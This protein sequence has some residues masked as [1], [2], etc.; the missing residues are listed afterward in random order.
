[1]LVPV[2]AIGLAW[3]G[4]RAALAG[5]GG[6][7]GAGLKPDFYRRLAAHSLTNYGQQLAGMLHSFSF[8][9]LFV[10]GLTGPAEFRF[11]YNLPG[12]VLQLVF[13]PLSGIQVPLFARLRED[14]SPERTQAAYEL[15][16]RGMLLLFCPAAAGLVVLAP[17]LTHIYD[18]KYSA[19]W[20]VVAVTAVS[21]FAGSALAVARNIAM[22]HEVYRPVIASRLIGAVSL[23]LL[24]WLP[25]LYGPLGA[26]L[27]IGGA[28]L[29]AE[30]VAWLWSL[31]AL[32]LAYPW[33]FAGRTLLATA[34]MVAV[35]WPLAAW[36]L[37]VPPTLTVAE[38]LGPAL[39]G[40]AAIA[41]LG[42]LVYL[43]VFR[44]LGG[45]TPDDK[46]ALAGLRLPGGRHLLRLL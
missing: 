29:L 13:A 45:L 15:M 32:R 20:P 6:A 9:V 17:N 40:Q 5:V 44:L 38:R 14:H 30:A 11:G 3:A 22:V 4:A 41:A 16:S 31:R 33:A 1:V 35:V 24:F 25:P 37:P 42:G 18:P 12:Q 21:I 26:A 39:A 23:P 34:V 2:V 28:S 10:P 43:L 19:A 46:V 36:V 27:A 8:A 7:I